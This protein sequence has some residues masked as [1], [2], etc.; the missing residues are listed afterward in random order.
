[1]QIDLL[2]MMC[3]IWSSRFLEFLR[4]FQYG[5][6]M[7]NF[8][9]IIIVLLDLFYKEVVAHKGKSAFA[10]RKKRVRKEKLRKKRAVK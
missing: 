8:Y 3:W 6:Y 1:M 10:K 5:L 4:R 9:Y 2:M 7:N